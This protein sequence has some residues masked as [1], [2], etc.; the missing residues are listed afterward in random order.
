MCS[1]LVKADADVNVV[2]TPNAAEFVGMPTFR[3][4]SRNPVLVEV[5][6]EPVTG[7]IAHIDLA[8]SADLVVVAPASANVIA[9][10][11]HGLA[12]DMLSTCLLAHRR[13]T[14]LLVAPAMNTVMWEHPATVAN[15]ETL[16][17]RGMDR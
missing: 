16:K 11:A 10:L 5:F 2:L 6:D 8:Q 13:T 17:R 7:R 14:P 15:V 3:A 4:L 9:K 1:Q 12:D